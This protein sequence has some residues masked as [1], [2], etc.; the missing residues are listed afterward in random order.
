MEYCKN[1]DRHIDTDF[2]AEHFEDE[3]CCKATYGEN[4]T[5]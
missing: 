1:C 2:N 3:E 5:K 4:N